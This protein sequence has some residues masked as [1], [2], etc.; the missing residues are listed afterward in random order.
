MEISTSPRIKEL[1]DTPILG[2][3]PLKMIEKQPTDK[4]SSDPLIAVNQNLRDKIIGSNKSD[5][6][7][8]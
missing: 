5:C 6:S 3:K 7:L 4:E 2:K 1:D 8:I